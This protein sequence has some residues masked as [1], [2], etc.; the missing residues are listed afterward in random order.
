M[1]SAKEVE[2]RL[3]FN[4]E[5]RAFEVKGPGLRSHKAFLAKVVRATLAMGN[6]PDGG[7]VCIGIDNKKMAAMQP[8]LDATQFAEW[9]SFDAVTGAFTEYVDPP[10]QLAV[11]PMSLSSGVQ[12]VVIDVEE[13]RDIPHFCRKDYPGLLRRGALYVRPRGKPETVEV[14][15]P[16]E[17]R[18]VVELATEKQVRRFLRTARAGGIEIG[19]SAPAD[20]AASQYADETQRGWVE[21]ATDQLSLIEGQGHW[22][23]SV[24]PERYQ[25]I[26][27]PF[28]DLTDFVT[29]HTVRLRGWPLP[30]VDNREPVMHGQTWV[31]QDVEPRVLPHAEA[32][33]MFQSGQ[34]LQKRVISAD[35]EQD[36]Q[37]PIAAAGPIIQVWEILFYLTE[38][39]E[40]AARMALA[41]AVDESV[42][43]SARLT[44][45]EGRQLVSGSWN[46]DI[47]GIYISFTDVLA[48]EMT[49][50]TPDV[51]AGPRSRAITMAQEFLQRF[52][53]RVPDEV[54]AD[55]Q[56]E[57]GAALD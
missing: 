43:I 57:L 37:S 12:V 4:Y 14:S 45:M 38:V 40:L 18:E 26:R 50:A 46:R 11:W 33:R 24:R 5:T 19:A 31:G 8:G 15:G 49:L 34:F 3:K 10:L 1:S 27:I 30:F 9:S 16:T 28:G 22:E 6:L 51:I 2:E 25:E 47:D 17:L 35:L 21:T 54:L 52:G 32:W 42:H 39:F 53:L 36:P 23:I 55:W 48:A 56:A 41:V 44:G 7:R 13:F 20:L 29:R